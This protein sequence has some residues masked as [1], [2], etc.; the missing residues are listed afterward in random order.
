MADATWLT[1]KPS[2]QKQASKRMYEIYQDVAGFIQG[3]FLFILV[4]HANIEQKDQ[5]KIKPTQIIK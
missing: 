4:I 1:N 3:D 2:I 5:W